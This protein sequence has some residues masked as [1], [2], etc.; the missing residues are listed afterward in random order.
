VPDVTVNVILVLAPD[1][2]LNVILV[3]ASDPKVLG[4]CEAQYDFS[5]METNQIAFR[6][7]ER[8][9]IL[10]KSRGNRGWW[11]GRLDG[12]VRSCVVLSGVPVYDKVR[13]RCK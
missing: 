2:A 8:I 10:S 13:R 11:K 7:G 1:A 5:P 3:L 6:V 4:Y 9:A 12:K